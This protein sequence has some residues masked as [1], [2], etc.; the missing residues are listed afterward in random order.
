MAFRR[1]AMI[2]FVTRTDVHLSDIPP[3][4][5]TDDWMDT[6][7]RKLRQVGRIADEVNANA[8]LDNGDFFNIKSPTRTSHA[9]IRKVAEVQR[10]YPCPTYGNI[11]NHDC[12]YGDYAYLGQQPLGVLF[13]TGVVKRCYDEHEAVFMDDEGLSA[14]VTGIP[15]HGS[16]YDLDRFRAQKK[17]GEDYL[18]V[19]AHV[20]A[21]PSGGSMFKGEDI[22]KYDDLLSLAPDVDVWF[23]G[24]W[25]KDQGITEIAP[26]KW[27]VNIGSLSRGS[28]AQD[29]LDRKPGCGIVTFSR[30]G[31]E[32]DRRDLDVL[33]AK[34]VFD[35][36][37]R[38]REET[39]AATMDAF[40]DSLRATLTAAEKHLT[41][42]QKVEETDV[43]QEVRERA[44]E[45]LENA[46]A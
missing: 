45:Y 3:K 18:M 15:Y 2:R 36:E 20:L 38:V 12:V 28:L 16:E 22:V 4:S 40:V 44:L 11:G 34:D 19:M 1:S 27:V 30:K 31:I 26:G 21:S 25:H 9:A 10:E 39:R 8:V 7:L 46:D 5:R 32:V 14:R 35:I 13:S 29:N 43:A 17:K 23:F 6:L 41:L 24:H 33:P 37:S 42:E